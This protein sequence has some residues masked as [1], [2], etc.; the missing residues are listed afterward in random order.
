MK[1]TKQEL[2]KMLAKNLQKY[3]EQQGK[4]PKEICREMNIPY[5]TFMQWAEGRSYPPNE[6]ISLM[7]DYFGIHMNELILENQNHVCNV[8]YCKN[9]DFYCN[10]F[11]FCEMFNHAVKENDFCSFAI[12]KLDF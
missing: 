12:Q 8:V 4:S 11:G 6:R 5:P 9:C 2:T 10:G 3:I 1:Y 7:A